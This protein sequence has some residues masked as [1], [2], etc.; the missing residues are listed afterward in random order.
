VEVL[1]SRGFGRAQDSL[2]LDLERVVGRRLIAAVDLELLGDRGDL[3]AECL[4]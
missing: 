3:V 4:S 1:E 2:D